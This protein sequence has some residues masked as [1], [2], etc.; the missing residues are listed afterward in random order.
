MMKLFIYLKQ[1]RN[2]GVVMSHLIEHIGLEY[3][4]GCYK[5]GQFGRYHWHRCD[6]PIHTGIHMSIKKLIT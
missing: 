6:D 2:S 4:R 5:H 3:T 1:K